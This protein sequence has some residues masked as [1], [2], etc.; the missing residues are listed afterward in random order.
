MPITDMAKLMI[1][2]LTSTQGLILATALT[3]VVW[4]AYV[5]LCRIKSPYPLPPGPPGRLLIGN[6]GQLSDDHPELD[7]IRWGKEYSSDVICLNT[8]GQHMICLNSTQAATDLLDR[9]GGN[10]CD[11]PRFTLFEIMGWGLTL[12]FLRWGPRFKLHRRLFQ[13][14]LTPTAIRAYQPIQEHEARKA[15]RTLL[16]N[17]EDWEET[18]LVMTTS[19]IFRI[20]FGQEVYDKSSPYCAMSKAASDVTTNGGIAGATLVDVFPPARFLPRFLNP[21]P[22]LRHAYRSRPAIRRIHEE[23]WAANMADIEKGTAAPSFMKKQFEQYRATVRAGRPTEMTLADIK[24]AT[25]AM[26]I[27]GG[28]STWGTVLSCMLFLTK[29]PDI[30]ASLAADI[31]RVLSRPSSSSPPGRHHGGKDGGG[32][33]PETTEDD[34]SYRHQEGA[35]DPRKPN[36]LP[37][38]RDRPALRSLDDFVMETM[39]C[40]PLNPLNIP[41]AP[42]AADVYRGMRIP[43]GATVFANTTA[44]AR[45]PGTYAS[46]GVFDPRRYHG[47]D[48]GDDGARGRGEPYPWGNFG[49]GRRRCPGNHLA[50]ASVHLFL[51]TLLAVFE[52]RMVRGPDGELRVPVPGVSVGLGGHPDKFEC[53]IVVRNED[54][55]RVLKEEEEDG[56]GGGRERGA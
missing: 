43:A 46:P 18:A 23:P 8:L 51:A 1:P 25:G 3:S 40:L 42:L 30:Q 54:M 39:R 11:R 49:Y 31:D 20:A 55:A 6:V 19:I 26:F 9:R 45:D 41:H 50:L 29:Y 10:Y 37:T 53:E 34:G 35:K 33:H 36:R 7:Y 12:T 28:N 44:I 47:G 56:G 4:L 48:D 13:N 38:F 5:R 15:V 22:P 16:D 24:G 17:P 14:N 27:A 32:G 52:L 2:Q 21:S